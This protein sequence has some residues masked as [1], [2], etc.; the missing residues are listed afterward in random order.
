MVILA[1]SRFF[2]FFFG[3]MY[4]MAKT[5]P[6]N[7]YGKIPLHLASNSREIVISHQLLTVTWSKKQIPDLIFKTFC[8]SI[9][10]HRHTQSIFILV[11]YTLFLGILIQKSHI[12][13]TQVKCR[14]LI[15]SI[16]YA[17]NFRHFLELLE[18]NLWH[19]CKMSEFHC[20]KN[21]RN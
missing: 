3:C 20:I 9:S 4:I 13:P 18:F 15:S 12:G 21:A 7:A 14:L 16:S 11:K 5:M 10:V 1:I 17:M 8:R 19:F 2:G 6:C